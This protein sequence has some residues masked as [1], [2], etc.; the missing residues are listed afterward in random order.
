MLLDW[1]SIKDCVHLC[2]QVRKFLYTG[3][4]YYTGFTEILGQISGV[5]SPYQNKEK[6][7]HEYMSADSF[8]GVAG[9]YAFGSKSMICAGEDSSTFQPTCGRCIP[10]HIM[11]ND[12]V[13]QDRLHG[14]HVLPTSNL[15]NL[16]VGTLKTLVYSAPIQNDETLCQ[17]MFVSRTPQD[18]CEVATV[19]DQECPCVH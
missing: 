7:L 4:P 12:Y 18:R 13:Y 10:Q 5:N 15:F 1:C 9:K 6:S 16:F 19:H 17:H 8:L 11:P 3:V 2:E 14:P